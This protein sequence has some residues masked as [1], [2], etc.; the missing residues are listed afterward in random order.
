MSR[1][2]KKPVDIPSGVTAKVDG[3]TV[4]AT[5]PKGTLS[6]EFKP[7]VGVAVE[8]KVVN[9]TR[10]GDT[11]SAKALHGTTRAVIANM[12]EGVSKGFEKKLEVRGVGYKAE[13]KGKKLALNVGFANTITLDVP[14]GLTINIEGSQ[15]SEISNVVTVSGS[16]KQSVGQFAARIRD[17]R[18]PEP[19]KG[20][21]IRYE[22]EKVI[23]KAGKAFGAK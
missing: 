9:V 14:D 11:G 5:G 3:H 18:K 17:V 13:L 23:Q 16:D 6:F 12:F 10:D 8:D 7:I 22:G 1:L 15:V 21:G 2:G 4:T 20:K 19:Y